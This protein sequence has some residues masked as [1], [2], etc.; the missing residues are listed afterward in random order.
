MDIGDVE[1]TFRG[2]FGDTSGENLV[3][4]HNLTSLLAPLFLQ[5]SLTI[6]K[7]NGSVIGDP[8]N[9]KTLPT[10][11]TNINVT[12]IFNPFSCPEVGT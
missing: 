7:K 4:N 11:E 12:F 3:E 10:I 2:H 5:L 8:K 6:K 9:I 1:S